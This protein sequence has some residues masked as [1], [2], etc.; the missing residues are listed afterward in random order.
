MSPDNQR[1]TNPATIR[2][3]P[4]VAAF[5]VTLI[6]ACFLGVA[7]NYARLHGEANSLNREL[8]TTVFGQALA[9]ANSNAYVSFV[10]AAII[11]GAIGIVFVV[12][13]FCLF[14]KKPD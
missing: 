13:G 9:I 10:T 2:R 7:L 8:S 6:G 12:F 3:S 14:R 11:F 1:P 4:R 5:A